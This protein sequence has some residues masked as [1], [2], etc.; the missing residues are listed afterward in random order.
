MMKRTYLMVVLGAVMLAA[1][2]DKAAESSAPAASTPSAASKAQKT[3]RVGSEISKPPMIMMGVDNPD[4]GF[5]WDLLQA[6]AEKQ[7]FAIEYNPETWERLLERLAKN[8]TD[9][10]IGQITITEERKQKMDFSNPVVTYQTGLM[11][12]PELAEAKQFSDLNGK[13]VTIR[14]NTV[15]EKL[16]PVFSAG[17]GSNIIYMQTAWEQ[18]K[19]L[20]QKES[21]AMTGAS[22]TLEYYQAKYPENKFHILYD[23]SY[24]SSQ[25]GWAVNKGNTELLEQINQGLEKV[26]ADGTYNNLYKKYWPNAPIPT[27]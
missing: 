23:S 25:Y 15:Y 1:C 3:Y 2:G 8:D 6:I 19:S 4:K 13:R 26:R 7:G 10:I 21:D 27:N 5:E 18:L 11:V 9:L 20:A 16:V 24:G 22:T 14:S 17:D 12:Q